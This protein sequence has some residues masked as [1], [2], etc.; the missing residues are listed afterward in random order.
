[1]DIGHVPGDVEDVGDPSLIVED[2]RNAHVPL[3]HLANSIGSRCLEEG[4]AAGSPLV[5]SLFDVDEVH[6]GPEFGHVLALDLREIGAPELDHTALI[7]G[8]DGALQIEDED[9]VGAA[10]KHRAAQPLVRRQEIADARHGWASVGVVHMVS[11]VKG[12]GQEQE[13]RKWKPPTFY[14][15]LPYRYPYAFCACFT[16]SMRQHRGNFVSLCVPYK[17]QSC[18]DVILPV[19][20]V[21]CCGGRNDD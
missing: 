4:A 20:F 14:F 5:Q 12:S 7:D 19:T 9:P 1:V 2:R 13:N 6:V 8:E 17:D 18:N 15:P 3:L 10:L 16:R 11:R 21:G